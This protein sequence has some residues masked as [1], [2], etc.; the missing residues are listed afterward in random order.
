MNLKMVLSVL[1]LVIV[2][3]TL[4][5]FF[6]GLDMLIQTKDRAQEEKKTLQATSIDVFRF[7]LEDEVRKKLGMPVEGYEPFMFTEV[8]PGLVE[9]DFDGVQASIGMYVMEEGRLVHKLDN[10]KLVHS[11]AKAVARQGYATL[12]QNIAKRIGVDLSK[13]GTITDIMSSIT[14]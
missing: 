12:L 14:S 7:T 8:F 3:N 13:D 1:V 5:V 2:F 11:A 6:G 4:F 9:T 10:S